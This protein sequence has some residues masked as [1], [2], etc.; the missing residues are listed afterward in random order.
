MALLQTYPETEMEWE[1]GTEYNYG[2]EGEYP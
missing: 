1:L 2:K